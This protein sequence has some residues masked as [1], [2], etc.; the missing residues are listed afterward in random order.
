MIQ[1]LYNTFEERFFRSIEEKMV[2]ELRLKI[3]QNRQVTIP[4]TTMSGA[5]A[6]VITEK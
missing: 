1:V 6:C 5:E 3:L 4:R 2:I